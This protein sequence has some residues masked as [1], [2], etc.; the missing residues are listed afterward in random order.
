MHV[1]PR[2]APKK[3]VKSGQVRARIEPELKNRAEKILNEMGITASQAVTM[4]YKRI[5]TEQGWPCELKI[6]NA[7]L[8]QTIDEVERGENTHEMGD[9]DSFFEDLDQ[10][11]A[12]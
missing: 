6:P 5:T 4:L 7:Q 8:S 11:S 2:G 3:E 12:G 10:D 1:N 9:L